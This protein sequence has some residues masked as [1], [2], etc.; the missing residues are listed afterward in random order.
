MWYFG[1]TER[2]AEQALLKVEDE[3]RQAM[4]NDFI[5]QD[6]MGE[7]NGNT[8]KKQDEKKPLVDEKK[9]NG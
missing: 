5:R 4:E 7:E 1:E 8:F 3:N 6:N 2:Q 9:D